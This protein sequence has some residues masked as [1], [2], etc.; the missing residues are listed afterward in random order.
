MSVEINKK[1]SGKRNHTNALILL[2]TAQERYDLL[3]ESG[4]TMTRGIFTPYCDMLSLARLLE[5]VNRWSDTVVYC[6]GRRLDRVDVSWFTKFLLCASNSSSS[7]C[8]KAKKN[9]DYFGCPRMKIGLMNYCLA[10]F[11]NGAQYWFSYFKPENDA[12]I[13][14]YLDKNKLA[15]SMKVP[16]LCPLFPQNTTA[17][18]DL[19]PSTVNLADNFQRQRW[20]LT[21]YRLRTR[22]LSRFPPLAPYSESIYR[23]W[24]NNLIGSHGCEN[25]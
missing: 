22:W 25:E 6:Q 17:V 7:R 15:N 5:T 23:Q 14:F 3:L 19:L 20:V 21:K 4:I 11:K 13:R 18:L 24:M 12:A 9:P 1:Q 2:E 10:S 16:E 8:E